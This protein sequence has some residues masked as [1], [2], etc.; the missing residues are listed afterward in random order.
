MSGGQCAEVEIDNVGRVGFSIDRKNGISTVYGLN[1]DINDTSDCIVNNMTENAKELLIVGTKL[2]IL[3][4][5][6]KLKRIIITPFEDVRLVPV[7]T[8]LK[9]EQDDI[10]SLNLQNNLYF[11]NA[12]QIKERLDGFIRDISI[13][14]AQ[15]DNAILPTNPPPYQDKWLFGT[16]DQKR[17]IWISLDDLKTSGID[18]VKKMDYT[19]IISM[20]EDNKTIYL[21]QGAQLEIAAG[22]EDNGQPK[23][24]PVTMLE[25]AAFNC[26]ENNI[27]AGDYLL[28][29][30]AGE[31]NW[32]LALI[33]FDQFQILNHHPGLVWD[34]EKGIANYPD[35]NS[36]KSLIFSKPANY[37]Y[38]KNYD[39]DM[40][41]STEYVIPTSDYKF[42]AI[43]A[44]Q[45]DLVLIA[46]ENDM[47][48]GIIQIINA[49]GTTGNVINLETQN[50][51]ALSIAYGNGVWLCGGWRQYGWAPLYRCTGDPS[52]AENWSL[53]DSRGVKADWESFSMLKFIDGIFYGGISNTAGIVKSTDNGA[54]FVNVE[55]DFEGLDNIKIVDIIETPVGLLAFD[56]TTDGADG[57]IFVYNP[58]N[59]RWGR[60]YNYSDIGISIYY[61]MIKYYDKMLLFGEKDGQRVCFTLTSMGI[62]PYELP[63]SIIVKAAVK[64]GNSTILFGGIN[65][66]HPSLISTV[67]DEWREETF[68]GIEY[69]HGQLAASIN[70]G[71]DFIEV[72]ATAQ[73]SCVI[74]ST[75]QLVKAPII[76]IAKLKVAAGNIVDQSSIVSIQ[77]PK[78]YPAFIDYIE[79][80]ELKTRIEALEAKINI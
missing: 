28:I 17:Q 29:Y 80:E 32:K 69:G 51:A 37:Y 10:I 77:A 74:R 64:K 11:L 75:S 42:T 12:E 41:F 79:K 27:A 38:Y 7:A 16:D 43:A 15:T 14:K 3:T 33:P 4:A 56:N 6:N 36:N 76:P 35:I 31:G 55:G 62:Q 18:I 19:R 34:D 66:W 58:N 48:A 9:T 52:K 47:N 57:R 8:F 30:I 53:V 22:L 63:G 45:N 49:D 59:D 61:C 25:D 24:Y 68:E 39:G 70:D 44:D 21:K 5:N 20:S 1:Y 54:S 26:Q 72:S 13:L 46:I 65:E 40:D 73:K 23:V 78:N 2:F 67:E 71:N 60:G 50:F